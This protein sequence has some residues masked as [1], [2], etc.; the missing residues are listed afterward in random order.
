MSILESLNLLTYTVLEVLVVEFVILIDV[1]QLSLIMI[2]STAPMGWPTGC[3]TRSPK[4]VVVIVV[5][6]VTKVWWWRITSKTFMTIARWPWI[7][8]W[9]WGELWGC[10]GSF[11]LLG[12]VGFFLVVFAVFAKTTTERRILL[13][14]V[15]VDAIRTNRKLRVKGFLELVGNRDGFD[16]VGLKTQPIDENM[17]DFVLDKLGVENKGVSLVLGGRDLEGN[18]ASEGRRIGFDSKIASEGHPKENGTHHHAKGMAKNEVH[19]RVVPVGWL[20]YA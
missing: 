18:V 16:G 17:A 19:D 3:V 2:P 14:L 7:W 13:F 15:G 11:L 9:S 8:S 12:L 5:K 20:Q 6:E 4:I 10:H 1:L